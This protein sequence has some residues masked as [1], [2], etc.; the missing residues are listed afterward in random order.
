MAGFQSQTEAK[1]F[2]WFE[3]IAGDFDLISQDAN[4]YYSYTGQQ[5][6][7]RS[8]YIT[9]NSRNNPIC[10]YFNMQYCNII[11]YILAFILSDVNSK[12]KISLKFFVR[13]F[14]RGLRTASFPVDLS[15]IFPNVSL[16]SEDSQRDEKLIGST[17]DVLE[18]DEEEYVL[19]YGKVEL[20]EKCPMTEAKC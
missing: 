14:H 17:N 15:H 16:T 20:T 3:K 5:C 11:I 7:N 1:C 19:W 18:Q 13:H 6:Y 4:N 10:L 9:S 12:S 2:L 8:L